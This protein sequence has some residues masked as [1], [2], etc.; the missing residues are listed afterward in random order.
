MEIKR[1][2]SANTEALKSFPKAGASLEKIF[3]TTLEETCAFVVYL[4]PDFL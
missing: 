4:S 3:P 2:V 1:T